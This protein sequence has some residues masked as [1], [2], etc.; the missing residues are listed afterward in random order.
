VNEVA[1]AWYSDYSYDYTDSTSLAPMNYTLAVSANSTNGSDGTWQTVTSILGNHARAREHRIEFAGMSWIKMTVL[2][3]Q[4]QPSQPYVRI[5]EIEVFNA[6]TLG[7]SSFFFSG[8]SITAIAYTRFSGYLP[9][10]ADDLASCA[11]HQYPLMIDG[12][13]GGQDSSGAVQGIASWLALLPDMHYWLLAW[14]SNDALDQVSPAVF[15][16]NLQTV[17]TAV[18]EQG[19][20]PVLAQIPYSTYRNLP[21]LDG[22]I[23]QL[24]QVIDEVTAANHLAGGPDFYSLFRT[25]PQYLSSDGLHPSEAG[26][27][28]MNS[29]WLETLSSQLGL[30]RVPCS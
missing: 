30:T 9:S 11:P 12:G 21:W 10:F 17:V 19:D 15:R 24:N 1:L 7:D 20:V 23:R 29:L 6:G 27:I 8:D 5:D 18:L 4:P 14:G 25:H 13:F 3:A 2:A 26:A 22:E 16:A 28:A